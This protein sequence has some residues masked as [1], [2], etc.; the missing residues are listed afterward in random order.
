MQRIKVLS[1]CSSDAKGGAARAAY[2]IHQGVKDL[3]VDSSMFVKEKKGTDP[4]VILLDE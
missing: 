3:G 4:D 1:V 2:R